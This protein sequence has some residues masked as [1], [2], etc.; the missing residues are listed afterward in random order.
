M[1]GQR[2]AVEV[3]KTRLGWIEYCSIG[4]GTPV[5]FLHGGHSNCNERLCLKGF[6][7]EKYQLIIL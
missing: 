3:V 1:R 4:E 5:L 7:R 6:D 2:Y